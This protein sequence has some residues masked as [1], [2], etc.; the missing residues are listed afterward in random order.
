M[1]LPTRVSQAEGKANRA[2]Y[3]AA[4]GVWLVW[5]ERSLR[6]SI[7]TEPIFSEVQGETG[8]GAAEVATRAEGSS[9]VKLPTLSPHGESFMFPSN[10]LSLLR[11]KSL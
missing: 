9:T 4:G 5:P 2:H 1:G 8:F 3:Y 11:G 6:T 7:G 10:C